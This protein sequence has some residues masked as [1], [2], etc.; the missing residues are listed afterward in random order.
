[1]ERAGVA[2]VVRCNGLAVLDL[3]AAET[4]SAWR[5]APARLGDRSLEATKILPIM[6]RFR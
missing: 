5:S 4:I 2:E 6:F 1:M 3:Q